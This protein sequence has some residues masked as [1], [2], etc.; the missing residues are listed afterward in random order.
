M[1]IDAYLILILIDNAGENNQT[2]FFYQ[3]TPVYMGENYLW[4]GKT[5]Q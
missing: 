3:W 4:L 2:Y 1:D 5:S